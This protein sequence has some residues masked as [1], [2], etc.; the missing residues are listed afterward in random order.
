M[1]TVPGRVSVLLPA[2]NE[3]FLAAT[4]R[5]VL[6]HAQGDVEV[7]ALLDGVWA[8]PVLPE[9][10]RLH[11]VYLG[12][13]HGMRP[14]LN[15]GAALAT[16][17]YL[18]KLDAHCSVSAGFDLAL[19]ASCEDNWLVVP[20]RDRLDAEAWCRQETGKPPIDA[21]YLSYPYEHPN[22]P[23]CGLHGVIWPQRAV[24]RADVWLDDEMSSQGSCWFM[25]RAHWDRIGPFDT[26][27]FGTSPLQEIQELG[28]K[29]WFG[30][31]RMVVNKRVTYLHLHKGSRYGRG[32]SMRDQGAETCRQIT[33][34][35][36]LHNS[37]PGQIHAFAW[38]IEKFWPVPTWP[39]DWEAAIRRIE[40]T[41]ATSVEILQA[42]YGVGPWA[43]DGIDVTQAVRGLVQPFV[44]GNDALQVGNIFKGTRKVLSVE[45]RADG[46]VKRSTFPERSIVCL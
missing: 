22:D 43:A 44:V 18:M 26:A 21:H 5:D 15:I 46:E 2:C 20:R 17:Q 33:R 41:K 31:G 38:L 13:Q 3:R 4:V 29:T 12:H 6:A 19:K 23:D 37:W 8:N 34:D 45:Y 39:T 11:T 25:T 9:D 30:G 1:T 32:Y 28:L 24:A 7:W 27:R 35:Y 40:G 36:W 16:G 14:V 42:T 10:P